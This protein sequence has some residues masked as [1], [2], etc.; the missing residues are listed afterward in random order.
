MK[1]NF[2]KIAALLIAAML[3]VVSCSQEVKAPE[4]DGLVEVKLGVGYGRDLDV[5]GAT[6]ITN[7]VL[8][9]TME[10]KWTDN[11][12]TE[13]IVGDKLDKTEF[14]DGQPIGYVTPGLWTIKVYAYEIGKSSENDRTIFE[15]EAQAYFS[16]KNSSVTVYL[17][18]TSSQS[19]TLKFSITMQDLV[20]T[21]VAEGNTGEGSYQ[22][23]YSVYGTT[24][25][26]AV[27]N[28]DGSATLDKVVLNGSSSNHVT[29]YA[30]TTTLASGFYR[31]N[32]SIYSIPKNKTISDGTLVGGITKGFLLS[33]GKTAEIKGHIEPSDYKNVSIDAVYL[34]V[35]TTLEASG[36][37]ASGTEASGT[38]VSVVDSEKG[39]YKIDYTNGGV[40]VKVTMTD[41]TEKGDLSA[42]PTVFWSAVSDGE[43]A[44]SQ[45]INVYEKEFTFNAPG[46]KYITCTTV[47]RV[48]GHKVNEAGAT[49]GADYYFAD[50]QTIRVFVDPTS[51]N[52]GLNGN[53]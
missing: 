28:Y 9:Y 27:Q 34:N 1:K 13:T 41:H 46:Y 38:E 30:G 45:T 15:G 44:V 17:A 32:V 51:Y 33:G 5:S 49:V 42:E 31:V 48:T 4:N 21:G 24:G 26:N 50:S 36:T 6:D 12:A 11:S 22:L 47:Y 2:L 40:T 43:T 14:T 7:M 8:K 23:V 16:N 39:Y 29:T 20:G 53:K 18:P 37:E 25:E 52:N 3:L 35:N 10:H 19:N